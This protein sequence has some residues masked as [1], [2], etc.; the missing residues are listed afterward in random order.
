ME[1]AKWGGPL[2]K[3]WETCKDFLDEYLINATGALIICNGQAGPQCCSVKCLISCAT[4]Y[5]PFDQWLSTL[6]VCRPS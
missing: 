1:L 2:E 6:S 4:S 5:N 3:S